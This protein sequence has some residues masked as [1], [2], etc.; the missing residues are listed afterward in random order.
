MAEN[1]KV[2]ISK[3]RLIQLIKTNEKRRL[4]LE[5]LYKI[6]D[7]IIG[8]NGIPRSKSKLLL[9]IPKIIAKFEDSPELLDDLTPEL[10]TEIKELI[11]DDIS[12]S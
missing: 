7:C 1:Q 2:E 12:R 8:E 4:A 9:K 3:A 5:K 10:L 11:K 6:V